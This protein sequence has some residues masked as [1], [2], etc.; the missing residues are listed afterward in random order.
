MNGKPRQTRQRFRDVHTGQISF[1][2]VNYPGRRRVV[3]FRQDESLDLTPLPVSPPPPT[4]AEIECRQLATELIGRPA[5]DAVME[6]LRR[7]AALPPQKPGNPLARL[8]DR[9]K[10]YADTTSQV[11]WQRISRHSTGCEAAARESN[12]QAREPQL[13]RILQQAARGVG[14]PFL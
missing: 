3:K 12:G 1:Q 9:S 7:A 11:N 4:P 8:R 6:S 5:D 10:E 13:L 14:I 2:V